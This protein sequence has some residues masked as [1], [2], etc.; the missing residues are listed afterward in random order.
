MTD[1]PENTTGSE[2]NEN[3]YFE[4]FSAGKDEAQGPETPDK[5]EAPEAD[6]PAEPEEPQVFELKDGKLV[7]DGQEMTAEEARASFLRQQD[8][9]RKTME[10]AEQRKA[11]EAERQALEPVKRVYNAFGTLPHEEQVRLLSEIE[12]SVVRHNGA[13][14]GVTSL[15]GEAPAPATET[16]GTLAKKLEA[17]GWDKE[18]VQAVGIL[19]SKT[20]VQ[21][22]Q[23][24]KLTQ[25]LQDMIDGQ[26]QDVEAQGLADQFK[27]K[28]IEVTPAQ[29]RQAVK[30]TGIADMEAAYLKQ[31]FS[32]LMEAKPA[33]PPP[34]EKPGTPESRG[35]SFTVGPN[36]TEEEIYQALQ[37][38]QVTTP[39]QKPRKTR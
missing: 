24:A 5:P 22:R 8:Y 26:K 38:G 27:A 31:N 29:L 28:G 7:F 39:Y 37:S 33:A 30:D 14:T 19:E 6:Q 20:T 3:D 16:A 2:Q 9:T 15:N 23:I 1:E 13:G 12:S 34:A 35:N 10:A 25:V 21:D 4:Q 32:K 18:M 17:E 11:V 36:T